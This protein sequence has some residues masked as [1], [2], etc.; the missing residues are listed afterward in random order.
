MKK[1]PEDLLQALRGE[2][3]FTL[4]Q[5]ILLR[6]E[7]A[8]YKDS[9]KALILRRLF[10]DLPAEERSITVFSRDT[11]LEAVAAACAASSLFGGAS[12]V[13]I[14]DE[15]LLGSSLRKEEGARQRLDGLKAILERNLDPSCTVL[16]LSSKLDG[17]SKLAKYISAQGL[18]CQCDPLR[19]YQREEVEDWLQAQARR[20]GGRLTGGALAAIQDYLAIVDTVPMGLLCQELEK[21]ALYAGPGSWTEAEVE[22]VFAPLPEAGNFTLVRAVEERKLNLA[23]TLLRQAEKS[24]T[25]I[26]LLCGQLLYSLRQLLLVQEGLAQG[27]DNKAIM[28][29]A[30]LN[31]GLFYRAKRN[32]GRFSSQALRQGLEHIGRVN[33]ELRQGGRTYDRLQEVIVAL[34]KA[35]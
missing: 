12:L 21:L 19:S 20:L 24:R 2:A 7:E 11:E 10:G 30:G 6:G 35:K 22:A 27:L 15:R 1:T 4:P 23:L 31:P 14:E 33:M 5:L 25:P 29:Q 26:V 9:I 28:A 13:L 32:C 8:Y 3:G 17:T 16:L 18:V 34:L